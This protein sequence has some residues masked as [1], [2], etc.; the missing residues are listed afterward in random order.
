M[1]LLAT[2]LLIVLNTGAQTKM[3]VDPPTVTVSGTESTVIKTAVSQIKARTAS[4]ISV[5]NTK[6]VISYENSVYT[7]SVEFWKDE[8]KTEKHLEELYTSTRVADVR[9]FMTEE[10]QIFYDN[11]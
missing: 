4:T 3:T 9:D 11:L 5:T 2:V 7:V 8:A 10:I 6:Y 1:L